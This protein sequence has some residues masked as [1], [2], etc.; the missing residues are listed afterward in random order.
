MTDEEQLEQ[1]RRMTPGERWAIA[2][3]LADLGMALWE[4]NLTES[5][6]ERRWEIWRREHDISNRNMLEAF[7]EA[8]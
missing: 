3:E 4:A 6:I 1:Y 5:E 7:R 8:R 2:C